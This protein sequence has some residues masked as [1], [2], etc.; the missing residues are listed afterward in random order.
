MC[1]QN[2]DHEWKMKNWVFFTPCFSDASSPGLFV[3]YRSISRRGLYRLWRV[4]LERKLNIL[5]IL[6]LGSSGG[7]SCVWLIAWFSLLC[8]WASGPS[9]V[10]SRVHFQSQSDRHCC[11]P[12]P[13]SIASGLP[14]LLKKKIQHIN[15]DKNINRKLT[16]LKSLLCA[17]VTTSANGTSSS[18][19][20]RW[21]AATH[22]YVLT[23]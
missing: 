6:Y 16:N 2:A 20:H 9:F 14:L 15:V 5:M 3:I 4:H 17:L 1:C 21:Y 12:C 10:W 8:C 11:V 18:S 19:L 23:L 7:T 22:R 13:L